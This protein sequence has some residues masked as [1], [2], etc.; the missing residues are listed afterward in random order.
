MIGKSSPGRISYPHQGIG[1]DGFCWR[2]EGFGKT[3]T[4]A[5]WVRDQIKS[6]KRR[7]ALVAPTAADAR[8]VMVEGESGILSVFPSR[9]RPLAPQHMVARCHDS[10]IIWWY[11]VNNAPEGESPVAARRAQQHVP[12]HGDAGIYR[13]GHR[14]SSKAKPRPGRDI[15]PE[16]LRATDLPVSR[17]DRA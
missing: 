17:T 13:E 5:E 6:G 4:G 11:K 12:D 9:A 7:I 8:D 10:V 14:A 1:A 15:C 2:A 16:K 3:R